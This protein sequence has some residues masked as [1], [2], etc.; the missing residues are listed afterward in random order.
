MYENGHGVPQDYTEA[1]KWHSLA[2]ARASATQQQRFAEARDAV[3]KFLTLQQLADAQQ[4]A[5]KWLEE[6]SLN[7]P[8]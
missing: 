6:W 3:A 7:A 2:A 5:R 1:Y 8:L 4:R